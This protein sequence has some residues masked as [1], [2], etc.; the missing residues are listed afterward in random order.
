MGVI[1]SWSTSSLSTFAITTKIWV[2]YGQ[3]L[4][5]IHENEKYERG[6]HLT[7]SFAT[8]TKNHKQNQPQ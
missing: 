1:E 5:T 6:C 2:V 4:E 3:Q 8:S 7:F